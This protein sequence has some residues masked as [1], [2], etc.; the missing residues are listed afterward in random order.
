[1]RP[2]PHVGLFSLMM[3]TAAGVT[4]SPT[5]RT[6]IAQARPRPTV[7]FVHLHTGERLRL[8]PTALPPPNR[9]NRFLR[10]KADKKYTLM[11]PRL[12]A[13]AAHTALH[14]GKTT[15]HVVSAFRS[16]AVNMRLHRQGHGVAL[17]SRHIH[18]QALDFRVVGLPTTRLCHYLRA[19]RFG[20]V[21][22]Y[23]GL[24]FV[25][26]DVGP[27]RHWGKWGTTRS[28][29]KGSSQ[30]EKKRREPTR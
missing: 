9:I 27:V 18:G 24:R 5:E 16:L 8:D 14:F 30:E 6:T 11:D 17:R 22:C 7:L 28:Q 3:I 1:M 20:G 12:V 21:G 2:R 23:P 13:K 15:V 4:G 19:Q 10:S 26:L 25:H 29:E